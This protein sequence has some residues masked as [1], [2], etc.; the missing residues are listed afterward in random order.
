VFGDRLGDPTAD[1]IDEAVQGAE[2]GLT[3]DQIRDLF[4]R[5]RSASE[6]DAALALLEAVGR[7][8][9]EPEVTGGRPATRYRASAS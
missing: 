8:V 1:G 6:L 3:R 9:S 2:N 5:H 7:I 4:S